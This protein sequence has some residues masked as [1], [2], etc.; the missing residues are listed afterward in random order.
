MLAAL[1][2]TFPIMPRSSARNSHKGS[3]RLKVMRPANQALHGHRRDLLMN[4]I[5]APRGG[6]LSAM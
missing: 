4:A 6:R 1:H 5:Q 3:K 2:H